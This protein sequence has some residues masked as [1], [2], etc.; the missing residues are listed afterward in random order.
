MFPCQWDKEVLVVSRIL[1]PLRQLKKVQMC[2]SFSSV[3]HLC[4]VHVAN[5]AKWS[6][7]TFLQ[8]QID[9]CWWIELRNNLKMIRIFIKKSFSA[10]RLISGA[11]SHSANITINL[12]Q[13]KFWERVISRFL[14]CYVKSMV[15]ANKSATIDELHT[16]IERKIAAVLADLYLKLVKNWVRRLDFCKRARGGHAEEI[17]FHS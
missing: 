14:W 4:D 13:T 15:Y 1:L 16:N 11:T 9:A 10:M 7:P 2:T 17:K 8:N 5:F 3:G 6:W 12:L